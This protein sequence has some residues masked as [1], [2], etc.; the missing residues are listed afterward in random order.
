MWNQL[1]DWWT[2][3]LRILPFPWGVLQ[4]IQWCNTRGFAGNTHQGFVDPMG[5]PTADSFQQWIHHRWKYGYTWLYMLHTV[6]IRYYPS[7]VN[8][9]ASSNTIAQVC[10]NTSDVLDKFQLAYD[11][12]L[13]VYVDRAAAQLFTVRPIH[14][15]KHRPRHH[16]PFGWDTAAAS[17]VQSTQQLSAAKA[18][19]H[20]LPLLA[21]VCLEAWHEDIW[22]IYEEL[23]RYGYGSIPINTIFSGM[24]IHLPAILM[25]TRGTRFWHTAIYQ[26]SLGLPGCELAQAPRI[27]VVAAVRLHVRWVSGADN[28][29]AGTG[30]RLCYPDMFSK[31]CWLM[32]GRN[33]A[34]LHDDQLSVR[35]LTETEV[36]A[37]PGDIDV[38]CSIL[39][40]PLGD[41]AGTEWRRGFQ[42]SPE[43]SPGVSWVFFWFFR[44]LFMIFKT[45][46]L[47]HET[48]S[49]WAAFLRSWPFSVAQCWA[50]SWGFLFHSDWNALLVSPSRKLY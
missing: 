4:R 15:R 41:L 19:C 21:L 3:V 31:T 37:S 43:C 25:F 38:S 48:V 39:G 47:H 42:E 32:M 30:G 12:T 18:S 36:L 1:T 35:L 5:I 26:F 34:V 40:L 10:S 46:K 17:F 49:R 23:W 29:A 27:R 13:G 45:W 7:W 33:L 22:L 2:D 24:N 50:T 9:E 28:V 11:R 14:T 8:Y 20:I 44:I 6:L 16:Y